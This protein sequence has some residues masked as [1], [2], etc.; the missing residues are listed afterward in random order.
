MGRIVNVE[1]CLNLYTFNNNQEKVFIHIEDP[2]APWNT[3]SYLISGDGITPFKEKEGSRCAKPA[4]RGL[5]MSI[6]ALT[7]IIIGYKRPL[8]LY[9]LDEIAGPRSDVEALERKIPQQKSFFYDFF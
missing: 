7:A 5:H 4:A 3:G 2:Y 8:E 1:N 9:D 6:N